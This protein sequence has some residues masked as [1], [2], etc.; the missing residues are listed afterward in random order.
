MSI[1]SV[2]STNPNSGTV[3]DLG[4]GKF[5]FPTNST[6]DNITYNVKCINDNG[7]AAQTTYT[8]PFC[9][10][11]SCSCDG[12]SQVPRSGGEW[13]W[14]QFG[15][16]YAKTWAITP[17]CIT[18]TLD[19]TEDFDMVITTTTSNKEIKIYPKKENTTNTLRNG[20]VSF[21]GTDCTISPIRGGILLSQKAKSSPPEIILININMQY[22]FEKKWVY[23][24][25]TTTFG[26][27]VPFIIQMAPSLSVYN[28]LSQ[29]CPDGVRY[30]DKVLPWEES[31]ETADPGEKS[32]LWITPEG[33]NFCDKEVHEV[34]ANGAIVNN[35]DIITY[36]G[37][38]Y[39][40]LW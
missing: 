9:P 19:N 8:I 22:F 35:G 39:K 5:N 37:Q 30:A 25:Y 38:K 2:T 31:A 13:E 18:P 32:S 17:P 34:H 7:C 12:F 21:K 24:F 6:S 20:F 40:I 29:I 10:V 27:S 26:G 14:S 23:G 16:Y 4:N 1:W 11:T 3:Q 28:K 15:S 33:E 36:N